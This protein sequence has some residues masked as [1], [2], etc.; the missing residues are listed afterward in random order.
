MATIEHVPF[1]ADLILAAIDRHNE[2]WSVF[3]VAP[4][5]LARRREDELSAAL[6]AVMG[7]PCLTRFGAIA[8]LRHLRWHIDEDGIT[9]SPDDAQASMVLARAADLAL[10][11]GVDFPP[12]IPPRSRVAPILRALTSSG[13]VLAALILVAGGTALAGLATLV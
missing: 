10:L 3:Q 4:D 1:H 11:L 9:A 7:T 8:L 12:V 5:E 6:D 2:A 13:E